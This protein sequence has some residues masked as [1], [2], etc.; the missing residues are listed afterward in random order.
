MQ[1]L[2]SGVKSSVVLQN[3]N[4]QGSDQRHRIRSENNKDETVVGHALMSA[5]H[6]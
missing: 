3:C 6:T 4:G 2:W 5:E 1:L